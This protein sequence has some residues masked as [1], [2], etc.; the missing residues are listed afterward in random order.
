MEQTLI[1]SMVRVLSK[2]T[3]SGLW[4]LQNIKPF[5]FLPRSFCSSI[6]LSNSSPFNT[7]GLSSFSTEKTLS[8]K[9]QISIYISNLRNEIQQHWSSFFHSCLRRT[10]RK[11]APELE[12]HHLDQW[13]SRREPRDLHWLHWSDEHCQETPSSC[14]VPPWL[15]GTW[16]QYPASPGC[17]WDRSNV[18]TSYCDSKRPPKI[19]FKVSLILDVQ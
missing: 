10:W 15:S 7:N 3:P 13:W 18:A 6:A 1:N 16:L 8:F 12:Q 4:G 17:H 14:S 2:T 11:L 19:G 9:I 5:T